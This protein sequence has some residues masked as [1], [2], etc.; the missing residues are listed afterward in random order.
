MDY[1]LNVNFV[2]LNKIK[3]IKIKIVNQNLSVVKKHMCQ[4][5]GK[6]NEYIKNK[7][8][9]DLKVDLACYSR[10]R[11]YKAYKV[12]NVGKT[13]KTFDFVE[14]SQSFFKCGIIHQLYGNMTVENYGLV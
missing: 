6:L 8:K 10:N 1:N 11:L 5:C 14:C 9:T 4:N 7:M 3:T 13:N 2:Q 12:Q